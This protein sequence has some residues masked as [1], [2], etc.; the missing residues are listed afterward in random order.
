M[1][2]TAGL[3]CVA[4]RSAEHL[5]SEMENGLAGLLLV[6]EAQDDS[7]VIRVKDSGIGLTSQALTGIFDLFV[8]SDADAGQVKEG[9]GIG[10]SLL[11][12]CMAAPFKP[13]L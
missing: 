5:L 4:C 2:Q 7:I 6:E 9:L 10:L 11:S 8:Q 13:N 1:L 3:H 12:K